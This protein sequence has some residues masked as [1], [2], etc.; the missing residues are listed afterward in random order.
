MKF[1][2]RANYSTVLHQMY[3][4]LYHANV[5]VDFVFPESTSL[6]DYKVIVVPPLYVASDALLVRLADFVKNG[7]RLVV[8]FKSGFCNEYST[9]RWEVM[10]GPLKAAA[11]FH[12]QEFSSLKQALPL[13]DDPFHAGP[14]N[15]VSEWAEMIVPD[16]AKALAYYDHPFFGKYPAI[17]RNEFGKGSFTYEGTVLSLRLQKAVLLGVL[18]EAGVTNSDQDLPAAVHVKHGQNRRGKTLHFYLNYSSMPQKVSYSY[19][20]GTNL[21]ST[22]A[23]TQGQSLLL[24]PWD[25]AIV[26]EK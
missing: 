13:A 23:V 2:D 16:T 1:S 12:Y 9:V 17:T 15:R 14:D 10:P 11:G 4:V 25:A 6:S 19:A 5:G 20:L 18:Q 26:E 24:Q 3:N 7:G 8:A 21:L 22:A